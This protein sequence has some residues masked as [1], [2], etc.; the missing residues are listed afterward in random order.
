V[1]REE[2][3]RPFVSLALDPFVTGRGKGRVVQVGSLLLVRGADS[4][5]P[6][7]LLS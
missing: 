7:L 5:I 6:L 3:V 4:L 2:E 1:G